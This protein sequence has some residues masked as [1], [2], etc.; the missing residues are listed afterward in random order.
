V[1]PVV[2]PLDRGWVFQHQTKFVVQL[3]QGSFLVTK[4]GDK[5]LRRRSGTRMVDV[6]QNSKWVPTYCFRPK[7]HSIRSAWIL[8]RGHR[9]ATFRKSPLRVYRG[10]K[11][12]LTATSTDTIIIT[13]QDGAS[14]AS[15]K[16]MKGLGQGLTF[17]ITC[18]PGVDTLLC[19]FTVLVQAHLAV[20]A[21]GTVG[22]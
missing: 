4:N 9:L 20:R 12:V 2:E 3:E 8:E 15:A 13:G 21:H 18:N 11:Q 6:R 17:T 22:K 19:I 1:E 5:V 10:D 7:K 14:V 16:L